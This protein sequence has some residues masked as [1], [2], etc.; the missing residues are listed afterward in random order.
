MYWSSTPISTEYRYCSSGTNVGA[1]LY[2]VADPVLMCLLRQ[3]VWP[4]SSVY[5]FSHL[6]SYILTCST[7]H[8]YKYI[9][10]NSTDSTSTRARRPCHRGPRLAPPQAPHGRSSG[11]GDPPVPSLHA[12]PLRRARQVDDGGLGFHASCAAASR[13]RT[14]CREAPVLAAASPTPRGCVPR[15]WEPCDLEN[16]NEGG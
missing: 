14:L 15:V 7:S 3:L 4:P 10:Y 6:M 8:S 16:E 11:L 5:F 1:Y 12:H 13:W 2:Q 9:S